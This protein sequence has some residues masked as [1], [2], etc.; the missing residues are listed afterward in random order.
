MKSSF[1][2]WAVFA[3][4]LC[5]P[6][7]TRANVTIPVGADEIFADNTGTTAAPAGSLVLLVADT[8]G[9]GFKNLLTGN[10]AVGATVDFGSNDL[11]VARFTLTSPGLLDST[12]GS[13]SLSGAW[14]AGDPLAI[15]WLPSLTS[16]DNNV[17][18][19]VAY[20]RYT[21]QV[22]IGGS[23]PWI[24]PPDSNTAGLMFFQSSNDDFFGSPSVPTST[25]FSA[26]TTIPEPSTFALL[27]GVM[28]LGI[29]VWRRRRK[30]A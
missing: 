26:F 8:T 16:A 28:A 4:L 1:K 10:I 15:Y 29:A 5:L 19:G 23:A 12:T 3:A 2:F 24:T 21:D 9:A 27:G 13:I 14:D 17:G 30:L 18:L 25:G 20:G 22:G 6:V 7:I 11:V